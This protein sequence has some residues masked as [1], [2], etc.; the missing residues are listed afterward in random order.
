[1]NNNNQTSNNW[2]IEKGT[3]LADINE[4]SRILAIA[5][6]EGRAWSNYVSRSW[7]LWA[8][9]PP[10]CVCHEIASPLGW[11]GGCNSP[12]ITFSTFKA[13]STVEKKIC[14]LSTSPTKSFYHVTLAQFGSCFHPGSAIG[15]W[16]Y[17]A[18]ISWKQTIHVLL[19]LDWEWTLG[20]HNQGW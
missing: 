15:Q 6:W 17:N 18:L 2:F 5:W 19:K 12:I 3:M 4:K 9:L 14:L 13:S 8:L 16:V 20:L 7:F 10:C 11:Q 1:M